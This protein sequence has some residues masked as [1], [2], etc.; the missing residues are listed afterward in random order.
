MHGRWQLSPRTRQ[1][2]SIATFVA[3]VTAA[4]L[5]GFR[6]GSDE[7]FAALVCRADSAEEVRATKDPF[8][9]FVI[10]AIGKY[11]WIDHAGGH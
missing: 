9:S 1:V 11:D 2:L 6:H 4:Y 10:S 8:R 5:A 7:T 3:T